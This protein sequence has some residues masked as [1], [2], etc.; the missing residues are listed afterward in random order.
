MKMFERLWQLKEMITQLD[1]YR[2]MTIDLSK[3]QA[4]DADPKVIHQISFTSNLDWEGQ[5]AMHIMLV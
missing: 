2:M 3:Q 1:Y 5:S 4:F